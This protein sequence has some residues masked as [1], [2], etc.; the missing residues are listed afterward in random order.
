VH[1]AATKNAESIITGSGTNRGADASGLGAGMVVIAGIVFGAAVGGGIGYLSDRLALGL[2][3]G[4][5]IGLVLGFY[6][7]YIQY[8]KPR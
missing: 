1:P 4:G 8:F 3:I 6:L 7:L 2:M 5:T